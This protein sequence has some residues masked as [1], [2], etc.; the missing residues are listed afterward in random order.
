MNRRRRRSPLFPRPPRRDPRPGRT[1][2]ELRPQD[3]RL[4]RGGN[5]EANRSPGDRDDLDDNSPAETDRFA[6]S[7]LQNQHGSSSSVAPAAYPSGF[8]NVSAAPAIAVTRSP[9]LP[10]RGRPVRA[11]CSTTDFFA[12]DEPRR[13]GLVTL[14]CTSATRP[15]RGAPHRTEHCRHAVRTNE[16]FRSI[17]GPE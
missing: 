16:V 1:S 10:R 5:A 12:N 2:D 11:L 17:N 4:G 3:R 7:S 15:R 14:R 9:R 13:E 8:G 6:G